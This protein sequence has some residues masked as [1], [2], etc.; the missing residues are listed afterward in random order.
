M[1]GVT[2]TTDFTVEARKNDFVTS[3]AQNWNALREIMG[4]ARPVKKQPGTVL[5]SYKATLTLEDGNVA[6]GAKIPLSEAKVEEVARALG[7]ADIGLDRDVT[8]L[9]GGQRTKVLL[10]KLL[11][12]F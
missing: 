1:A 5:K 8:D 3:F 6:E 9:S 2:V 4:I 10:A 7:L 11:L 12:F